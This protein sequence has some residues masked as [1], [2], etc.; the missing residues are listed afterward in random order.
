MIKVFLLYP[1]KDFDP[2]QTLPPNAANLIQDMALQLVFEAMAAND[3]YL[4]NVIQRVV[5]S[6][7]NEETTIRYRQ[8]ILQDCLLNPDVIQQLYAVPL[9]FLER[10]RKHWLWVSSNRSSP[11]SIL[12]SAQQML[13]ASLDLLWQL[14]RIADEHAGE[15]NSAGFERFFSMIQ[16]ELDDAYLATVEQQVR[17][18]RFP[19]GILLSARLGMGNEGTNYIL[20]KPKDDG[21]GLVRRMLAKKTPVYTYTLQPR[22]DNGARMLEALWNRGIAR[23]A[24]AVA[25]AAEHIESFFNVLR[26]ELAFYIGCLNLHRRLQALGTPVTYP[27]VVPDG[28]EHLLSCEGLYDITLALATQQKV[29]GNEVLAQGKDLVLITG[30]NQGGKTTFLRSIGQAQIMMQCGMFVPA[31]SFSANTVSGIFTHFKREEDQNMQ[32]GKFEE[33]LKRMSEIVDY[34]KPGGLILC[35]ESFSST[36]EREG[37]EIAWQI[38]SGLLEKQVQIFYVTHLY[39]FASRF[40]QTK[41]ANVLFLR[42]ERLPDGTRTFKQKQGEPLESSSGLDLF[43]KIFRSG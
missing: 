35:N 32:S 8:E 12:D 26:R 24:N 36:N 1:D 39:E 34:V 21:R 7:L 19:N 30:A 5:L 28:E 6:S 31:V 37:S 27:R 18:L 38:V 14:R 43:H 40:Y 29:V 9:E 20:C 3:E 25:Q 42:A 15:F 41:T 2:D 17:A 10:K 4:E 13:E 11:A 23:A 22:D 16:R 33:E